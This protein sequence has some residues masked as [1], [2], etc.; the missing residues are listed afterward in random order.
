MLQLCYILN[1]NVNCFGNHHSKE[2]LMVEILPRPRPSSSHQ[3]IQQ[4]L[5]EDARKLTWTKKNMV[6]HSCFDLHI[7]LCALYTTTDKKGVINS[8]K[9]YILKLLFNT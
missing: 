7:G 8:I 6:K 3:D 2:S 4:C 5:F 9:F 1:M